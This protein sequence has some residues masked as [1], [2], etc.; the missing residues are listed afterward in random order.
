MSIVLADVEQEAL[1][2]AASE[3]GEA[4]VETLAVKVD[5]SKE[6]E[7]LALA[8]KVIERFGRVDVVCNN[9]GVAGRADPWVGRSRRGSG[10]WA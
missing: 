2:A 5:V 7:V 4:G 1:D 3:I 8:D 6:A 10:S 9:A